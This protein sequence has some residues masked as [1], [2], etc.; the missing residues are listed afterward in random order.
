[1]K[2]FVI[3]LMLATSLTAIKAQDTDLSNRDVSVLILDK[4]NR[5]MSHIIV[6][7]LNSTRADI[8]D[9]T[10]LIVL[11]DVTDNDVISLILP[12]YGETHIP[13]TGMDSIVVT[14]RSARRY[15]YA[16][17]GGA[18]V[19]IDK[20]NKN[21]P[22]NVID[23]P[24]L[25]NQHAYKSLIELLQGQVPGL[26]ITSGRNSR[27][28]T[29]NIR[30][31]RS[32]MGSSEPLVVVNGMAMMGQNL[33]EIDGIVSVHD[34]KTIE[35]QKSSSEWGVRGANGVILIHTR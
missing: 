6:R 15:S 11:S 13:V 8:T 18:S 30:G 7:S 20:R 26:N 22:S 23:V 34:I 3:F 17:N 2:Y 29:V 33:A 9:L 21:E 16:V 32:L 27:E 4:K 12:R 25:M 35:V 14:L 28:S 1:M 19:L 10:G 5:P 24:A 31:E